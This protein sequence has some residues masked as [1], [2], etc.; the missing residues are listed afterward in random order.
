MMRIVLTGGGTGGHI[1]PLIS[2]AQAMR[3]KFEGEN[4]EIL[5]LGPL[6][7]LEKEI[8]TRENIAV[9][10]IFSGKMRR[11][12][13][14]LNFLDIFKTPIGIIQ[15][16]CQL[17]FFMPDV[18]FSKGGYGAVPV[19]LAAWIYRIPILTHESDA[20]P[21]TANRI[22]GKLANLVA[23]TYPS[24]VRYFEQKKVRFTGVPIREEIIQGQA[25]EG[26]KIFN[27]TESKPVIL[28]WG[29][30]QGSQIIN[31]AVINI[32][33]E[34]LFHYQIIHQTGEKN[35]EEIVHLA[36]QKGIK[37]GREGYTPISFLNLEKLKHALAV[38]DLVISRAGSTSIAEIAANRKPA[39]LIPLLNSANNHQQMNAFDLAQVQGALV[40][41]ENNLGNNILLEKIN[42]L[43]TNETVRK[44][45]AEKIFAFYHPHAAEDIAEGLLELIALKKAQ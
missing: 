38:S 28:V 34:L 36:G 32:L 29:G 26:R 3:K 44:T 12:F 16:L 33:P 14:W 7:K 5:Y 17:L 27:L 41:E 22:V 31:K 45:M 18:I 43:F 9:K 39:I 6:G 10:N 30:S 11:Y 21:G 37:A 8:F 13:S 42:K 23:I 4:L 20:I 35:F 40:L 25:E 15:S 19:V 2:V 1:F 24:T